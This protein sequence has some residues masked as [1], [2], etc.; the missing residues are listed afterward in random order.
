[1]SPCFPSSMLMVVA[2]LV[3]FSKEKN[4][5]NHVSKWALRLYRITSRICLDDG[6]EL[7][8]ISATFLL[9]C[10]I[11][12]KPILL[13][14]DNHSNQ[15][16]FQAVTFAKE[17]GIFVL[18]LPPHCS[19]VLQPLNKIIKRSEIT[20]F[21]PINRFAIP[22][23]CYAPSFV[24]DT[25]APNTV[26]EVPIPACQQIVQNTPDSHTSET[27]PIPVISPVT[28]V[29][30]LIQCIQYIEKDTRGS[31][32]SETITLTPE[33][34]TIPVISPGTLVQNLIPCIQCRGDWISPTK[35][36]TPKYQSSQS[37]T[38]T[39]LPYPS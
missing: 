30:N 12:I 4:C 36:Y 2:L 3:C 26:A 31:Q 17:N 27:S 39:Q 28:L 32:S 11:L 21:Y 34:S 16:D 25:P 1:M 33:T 29:Q 10:Q 18:K 8:Q 24:T 38:L 19:H 20:G 23:F 5:P 6:T 13:I 22:E 37:I 9:F 15:M 7:L 35:K 14:M